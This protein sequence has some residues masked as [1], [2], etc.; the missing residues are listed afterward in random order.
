MAK[1]TIVEEIIG[2]MAEEIADILKK[3]SMKAE[4]TRYINVEIIRIYVGKYK[5][6]IHLHLNNP[7]ITL[8]Y[9]N[10]KIKEY[11]IGDPTIISEI[12]III[13][14]LNGM[15]KSAEVIKML[16]EQVKK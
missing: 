16:V 4:V 2:S 15:K 3:F 8:Y 11:S 7:K 13:K 12:T 9:K 14:H 10:H 5:F 1:K 6:G